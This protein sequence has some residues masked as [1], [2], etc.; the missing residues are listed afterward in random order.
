MK[1]KILNTFLRLYSKFLIL[2]LRHFLTGRTER[3]FLSLNHTLTLEVYRFSI[4]P[5]AVSIDADALPNLTLKK[6]FFVG[7]DDEF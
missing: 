1:S 2:H 7:Y 6:I 3:K 5:V 4:K